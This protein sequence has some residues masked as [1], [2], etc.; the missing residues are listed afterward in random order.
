MEL[1]FY[2]FTCFL[3]I[4]QI[5]GDDDDDEVYYCIAVNDRRLYFVTRG[6]AIA[7][8]R[9]DDRLAFSYHLI[10]Y[11]FRDVATVRFTNF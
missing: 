3:L 1:Y 9:R 4:E 6:S 11:R 10:L 7:D 5:N 2:V 8:K